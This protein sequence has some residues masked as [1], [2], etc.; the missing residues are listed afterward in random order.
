VIFSYSD[1]NGGVELFKRG[2]IVVV[3]LSGACGTRVINYY[4]EKLQDLAA[5]FKGNP[6]VYLC[7]GKDFHATTLEAQKTIVKTYRASMEL[8][9]RYEAYCYDSAVGKAQTQQ[10]MYEC[11]NNTPIEKVLFESV[12]QAESY[13]LEKLSHLQ[14]TSPPT[15]SI[16]SQK[17]S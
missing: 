12:E 5:S 9:C 7:D 14:G 6:W 13:L 1:K 15:E 4:S 3:K 8:G 16:A 11:G 10:I 17:S 2:Q